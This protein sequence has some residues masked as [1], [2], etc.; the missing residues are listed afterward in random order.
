MNRNDI[1]KGM[2]EKDNKLPFTRFYDF[3]LEKNDL[4]PAEK[5]VLSI[6]C[7]Y[8][9]NPYWGSNLTIAKSLGF[10][11][12][13]VEM[14]IKRLA[15]K[16]YI[17]RGYAHTDKG[18]KPHTVRVIQPLCFSEKCKKIISWVSPEQTFGQKTEQKDGLT[19]NNRSFLTE[20]PFDLLERNKNEIKNDEIENRAMPAPLPAKGQ[21]SALPNQRKKIQQ[22][23]NLFGNSGRKTIA[24]TPQEFEQRRQ[25]MIKDLQV[26]EKLK[27]QST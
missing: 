22:L 27:K 12:R 8:W 21:A 18:G 25:K 16:R 17:K 3:L 14:I 2:P 23:T 11:E 6:I 15:K 1:P 7:R 5:L 24:P 4:K 10:S 13:Y 26:S 19:P 20:Q 9:P